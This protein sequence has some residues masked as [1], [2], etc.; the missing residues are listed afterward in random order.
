MQALHA[1]RCSPQ[2]DSGTAVHG[3]LSLLQGT[4]ALCALGEVLSEH[5]RAVRLHIRSC[6]KFKEV[7]DL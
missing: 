5:Q 7:N 6:S 4:A 1:L 2:V 3:T